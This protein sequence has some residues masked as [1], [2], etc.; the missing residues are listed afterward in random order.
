MNT[1]HDTH[2][3]AQSLS[4]FLSLCG[5]YHTQSRVSTYSHVHT[6]TY[7]YN[8]MLYF[9]HVSPH[10]CVC[11]SYVLY[12]SFGSDVSTILKDTFAADI[13]LVRGH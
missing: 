5:E 13:L 3:P 8:T 6:H 9:I 10:V 2:T 4:L 1:T 7:L 11:V 12:G